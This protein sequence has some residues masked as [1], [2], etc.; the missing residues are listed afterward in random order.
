MGAGCCGK[1]NVVEDTSKDKVPRT[2]SSLTHREHSGMQRFDNLSISKRNPL[3]LING[4]LNEPVVSLEEALQPFDGKIDQ[5]SHYIKEAKTKC[6]YPSKHNLTRDESA[7]IYIYTMKWDH[8]CLY[9][10][11]QEAWKSEDRAQLKPWFKYFKLFKTALD[12]LPD[13]NTEIWQEQLSSKSPS[14]F[15]SMGSCSPSEKELQKNLEKHAGRKVIRVCYEGIGGKL[16]TG[17]TANSWREV[18][19]WPGTK[20]GVAKYDAD[21]TTGS[22]IVHLTKKSSE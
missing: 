18:V 8:I 6:H 16:V 1:S 10:R 7:A 14:L 21:S 12:K 13:A 19:V 20:L 17:Y 11:L 4:Y 9:D 15:T 3:E 2:K 22:L 5:L